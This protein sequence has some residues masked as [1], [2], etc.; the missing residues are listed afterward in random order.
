MVY[1]LENGYTK[2]ELQILNWCI[3][4]THSQGLYCRL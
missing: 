1:S 3:D 4:I 2:K